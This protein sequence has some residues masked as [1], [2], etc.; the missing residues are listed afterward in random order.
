MDD[1]QATLSQ[2]SGTLLRN[3]NHKFYIFAFVQEISHLGYTHLLWI[4]NH[5]SNLETKPGSSLMVELR[6]SSQHHNIQFFTLESGLQVGSLNQPALPHAA[7]LESA[8][9][10]VSPRE[11]R[12]LEN[13]WRCFLH[14]H[15]KWKFKTVKTLRNSYTGMQITTLS[16]CHLQER[17]M[18]SQ[19]CDTS[20]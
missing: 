1:N 4:N 11:P 16:Y 7:A 2:E 3:L 14:L 8:P 18:W 17:D 19:H 15:A 13:L 5:F 10:C 9:L 12:G 20:L 6:A